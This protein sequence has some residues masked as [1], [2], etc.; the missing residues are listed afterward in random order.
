MASNK[1][2]RPKPFNYDISFVLSG[3][4]HWIMQGTTYPAGSVSE[5]HTR[6]GLRVLSWAVAALP[7]GCY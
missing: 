3:R 2:H 4:K 7:S 1:L 6:C 5:A